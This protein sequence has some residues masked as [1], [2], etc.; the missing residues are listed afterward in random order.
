MASNSQALLNLAI[1]VSM[2][3][4]TEQSTVTMRIAMTSWDA[5]M[6]NHTLTNAEAL[7]QSGAS[8]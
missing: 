4:V 7:M 2:M 6:T 8:W 5:E 1:T 3:M